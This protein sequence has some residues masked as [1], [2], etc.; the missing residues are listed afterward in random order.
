M[1]DVE[2]C[3]GRKMGLCELY[4]HSKQSG[5]MPPTKQRSVRLPNDV[6]TWLEDRA[7]AERR[8]VAFIIAEV[9][10]VEMKR[11]AQVRKR[12]GTS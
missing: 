3:Q 10:R 1:D 11:E 5:K 2:N 9:V 6:M 4:R 12:R 8:S 7:Q